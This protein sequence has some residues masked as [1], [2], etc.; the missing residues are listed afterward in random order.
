[1]NAAPNDE[2][3][4]R[5][6]GSTVDDL[7]PC[8]GPE[9]KIPGVLGWHHRHFGLAPDGRGDRCERDGREYAGVVNK[10]ALFDSELTVGED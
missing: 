8:A 10:Q 9:I 3:G 6:I 4:S 2:P 5:S 1:M 7:D